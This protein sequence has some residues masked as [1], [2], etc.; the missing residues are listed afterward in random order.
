[1]QREQRHPSLTAMGW[2]FVFNERRC[3]GAHFIYRTGR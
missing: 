1:M 3:I 2:R